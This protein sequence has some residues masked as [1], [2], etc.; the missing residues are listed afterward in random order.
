MRTSWQILS[1]KSKSIRPWNTVFLR[2]GVF[3]CYGCIER[4][5]HRYRVVKINLVYRNINIMSIQ[6]VIRENLI[7]YPTPFSSRWPHPSRGIQ[8]IV[9]FLSQQHHGITHVLVYPQVFLPMSQIGVVYLAQVSLSQGNITGSGHANNSQCG[10][11]LVTIAIYRCC[12]NQAIN[13]KTNST[14]TMNKTCF[15]KI[16]IITIRPSLRIEIGRVAAIYR[17]PRRRGSLCH[18]HAAYRQQQH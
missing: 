11:C 14:P 17:I 1:H 12:I 6:L 13:R 2:T 4:I 5:R 3:P 9:R 7:P 10:V 18:R 15:A 16:S 8:Y